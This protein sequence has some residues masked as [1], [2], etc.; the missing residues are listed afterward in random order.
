MRYRQRQQLLTEL[1][2]LIERQRIVASILTQLVHRGTHVRERVGQQPH[3]GRGFD[4]RATAKPP[5]PEKRRSPHHAT[6]I[7]IAIRAQRAGASVHRESIGD[8]PRA[9]RCAGAL[10]TKRPKLKAEVTA[11]VRARHRH[12][13]EVHRTREGG[14][15]RGA[16]ADTTLH[17]HRLHIRHEVCHIREVEDLILHVIERDTVDRDVDTGLVESAQA[18]VTVSPRRA[19][20]RVRRERW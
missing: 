17:L 5:C 9:K 20:F 11:R 15:A 2:P 14:G 7:A 1:V 6:V 4:D 12:G 8:E 18:Q 10:R 3:Q 19:I 16:G 13:L